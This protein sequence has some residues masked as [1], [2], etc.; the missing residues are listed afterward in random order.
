VKHDTKLKAPFPYFGGKSRISPTIWAAIGSDVEHYVEPFAGSA[1]ALLARPSLP[2]S[3]VETIND[4]DGFVANFWRAVQADP[5]AVARHADRPVNERDLE[6]IHYWLVSDAA[7]RLDG[8]LARPDGYDAQIAGWWVWGA[9]AWIGTGWC[10][11]EGPWSP[12]DAGW[13]KAQGGGVRR[14]IFCDNGR[15]IN[16]KLPHTG[17]NGQGI[18]RKLPYTGDNGRGEAR[19]AYIQA[20]LQALSSRLRDVRVASGDWARVLGSG[21]RL[22]KHVG[23]FLDPP[24]AAT[25]RAKTYSHDNTQVSTQARDW[26]LQYAQ[27]QGDRARI[28]FA[29]YEGQGDCQAFEDA[30]W[31]VVAWKAA[32]GF[33]SS[34]KG[35][36]NGKANAARERLWLSPGCLPIE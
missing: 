14:K 5:D 7:P 1:A 31:R 22:G 34:S 15:G 27:E 3:A 2:A 35:G 25:D 26:A 4:R 6:A 11:G 16:R 18:N 36:G 29:G 13:V 12:T 23:I 30:G 9:C 10:S 17:N 20:E 32:G 28:V 19:T 33:A 24:Y 21:L 8:I